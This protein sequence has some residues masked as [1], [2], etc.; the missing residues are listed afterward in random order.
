MVP[1]SFKGFEDYKTKEALHFFRIGKNAVTKN[2]LELSMDFIGR[3]SAAL[4]HT[5]EFFGG[6]PMGLWISTGHTQPLICGRGS[7]SYRAIVSLLQGSL[8]HEVCELQ[9][10][11]SGFAVPRLG[12]ILASSDLWPKWIATHARPFSAKFP[13]CAVESGPASCAQIR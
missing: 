10:P 11:I 5:Y 12:R 1:S 7:T 4:I 9:V 3:N 8:M 2:S 6:A 13:Q